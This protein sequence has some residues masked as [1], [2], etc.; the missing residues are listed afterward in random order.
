MSDIQHTV[1]EK[2]LAAIAALSEGGISNI[3]K[4]L[5]A[6]VDILGTISAQRNS[7]GIL[8]A[9]SIAFQT[10]PIPIVGSTVL[11]IAGIAVQTQGADQSVQYALVRD[12]LTTLVTSEADVS[13]GK[14]GSGVL[15]W[16]DSGLTPGSSH[17]WEITAT[18]QTGGQTVTVSVANQAWV[19]VVG[20]L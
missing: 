7:L 12:G 3:E 5:T 15:A 9:N 11:V 16:V 13:T 20:L 19:V 10:T 2:A 1:R 14:F 4:A 18:N 6:I 8:P 17:T